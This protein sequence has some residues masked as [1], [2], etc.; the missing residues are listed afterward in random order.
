[1]NITLA[2]RIVDLEAEHGGL[3]SAG[4]SIGIDPGYLSRLKSGDACS[5][6]DAICEKMGLIKVI[7]VEYVLVDRCT[8]I[9]RFTDT[10]DSI[11]IKNENDTTTR[12]VL[13]AD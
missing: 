10:R 12:I 5:P 7:K 2:N 11:D 8:E 3:R 4:K 1:M 9:Q 13:L 6:S